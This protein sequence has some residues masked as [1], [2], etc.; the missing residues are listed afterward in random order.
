[1]IALAPAIA[2]QSATLGVSTSAEKKKTRR[3]KNKNHPAVP[4]YA[5]SWLE[6]SI[7]N[8][9]RIKNILSY[10]SATRAKH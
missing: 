3:K 5:P 6:I 2:I 4:Q 10:L 7:T 9:A 1:M 8:H